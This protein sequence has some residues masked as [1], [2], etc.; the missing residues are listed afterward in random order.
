MTY[1]WFWV[2]WLAKHIPKSVKYCFNKFVWLAGRDPRAGG[3][4]IFK[5]LFVTRRRLL[6][7]KQKALS[8]RENVR[9]LTYIWLW[10]HWL[11]E[12]APKYAR[13]KL[14]KLCQVAVRHIKTDGEIMLTEYFWRDTI[15][16]EFSSL[17]L[18]ALF[19][20]AQSKVY[21]RSTFEAWL[22]NRKSA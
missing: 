20:W 18:D 3:E 7:K 8:N 16:K 2:Q 12:H 10:V 17:I 13:D 6:I 11:A 4:I 9:N 15:C 21:S 14:T 22:I 1:I 19:G 5:L